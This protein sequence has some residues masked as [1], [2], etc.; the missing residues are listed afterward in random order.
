MLCCSLSSQLYE[1]SAS[2]SSQVL[3]KKMC[4]KR[5][6]TLLGVP[7][8]YFI[9]RIYI[10]AGHL[11][12]GSRVINKRTA[13]DS[14][15]RTIKHL[16]QTESHLL[17][18]LTYHSNFRFRFS[19]AL[20]YDFSHFKSHMPFYLIFLSQNFYQ[21]CWIIELILSCHVSEVHLCPSQVLNT[22]LCRSFINSS[23]NSTHK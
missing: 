3:L 1:Q 22:V 10:T 17:V 20:K 14:R 8:L 12:Y 2:T 5:E 18:L 16:H 6:L 4:R 19:E 21:N 11:H 13:C 7:L 9:I 23:T 15:W